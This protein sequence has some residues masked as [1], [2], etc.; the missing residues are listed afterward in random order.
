MNPEEVVTRFLFENVTFFGGLGSDCLLVSAFSLFASRRSRFASSASSLERATTLVLIGRRGAIPDP[1]SE[2][3]DAGVAA[4]EGAHATRARRSPRRARETRPRAQAAFASASPASVLRVPRVSRIAPSGASPTRHPSRLEVVVMFAARA[5]SATA[6]VVAAD[7]RAPTRRGVPARWSAASANGAAERGATRCLAFR[8][9]DDARRSAVEAT[10]DEETE[11]DEPCASG[12]SFSRDLLARVRRRRR[13]G[14][15]VRLRRR[16]RPRAR[17]ARRARARTPGGGGAEGR[18]LAFEAVLNRDL[19]VIER[20]IQIDKELIER[21]VERVPITFE[22]FLRKEPP[23]LVGMLAIA[24]VNGTV[25]LFWALFFR[26]TS[27][28]PGGESGRASSRCAKRWSRASS[29]F[30]G[31]S[32]EATRNKTGVVRKDETPGVRRAAERRVA[33]S[34]RDDGVSK[35]K[36]TT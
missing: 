35:K 28:G 34:R 3:C 12:A 32:W 36:E 23:V 30:S 6:R 33:E 11:D 16:P 20:E 13:R 24:V 26:E 29:V 17:R 21:D 15:P 8:A 25:G 7:A 19:R 2:A 1:E 5:A 9:R 31:P 18:A 22:E 4:R 27:A 10:A 14:Q